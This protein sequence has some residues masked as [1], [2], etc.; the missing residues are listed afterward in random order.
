M[1]LIS[2][3]VNGLRAA[4]GKESFSWLDEHKPD[5][6][7][8]QE[9]K[10]SE[11]KIPAEI[12]NLGFEN[13]SA[14]SAKRPGY[15]GVMSLSNL[16]SQN[17]KSQFFDDDEGRVLEHKFDNIHL[18]N[19]YFP[20]GQSGDERLAYKM[21]FYDKF[22]SY[23]N[24]LVSEGKGVIF[25]GDVNT[26]H[27]KIDLK[28][29]KANSK[30]SGF[31]PIERAWIDRV[32]DSGFIDTFRFINGDKENAYSWWSYRFNARAKNVGWRID[33]FFISSNLKDKLK[34]AFILDSIEGSDHC[35]VG[36]EIDL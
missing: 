1:K 27:R 23:I 19:I 26:A 6:L 33:Y 14:N 12:Y 25:C 2:W 15:S 11:D 30:T 4:L 17:L 7:A 31:L 13:I 16:K 24:A 21:D 34:D 3:N 9:I 35:P 36:I 22:L 5:F 18:F 29:P 28:N 8:L 32:I 20:N 10:V